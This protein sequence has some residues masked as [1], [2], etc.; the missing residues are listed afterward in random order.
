MT[1]RV[2]ISGYGSIALMLTVP[3]SSRWRSGRRGI[4]AGLATRVGELTVKAEAAGDS[5]RSGACALAAE[6]ERSA[7]R[8]QA[9]VAAEARLHEIRTHVEQLEA[10]LIVRV[11]TPGRRADGLPYWRRRLHPSAAGPMPDE[12]YARSAR[13]VAKRDSNKVACQG[14]ADCSGTALAPIPCR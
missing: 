3:P 11:R 9:W 2:R 1:P 13:R 10:K 12:K 6:Q 8:E 5:P 4:D 14:D 7:A